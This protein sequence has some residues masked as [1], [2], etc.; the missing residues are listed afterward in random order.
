MKCSDPLMVIR[1]G[2]LAVMRRRPQGKGQSN[3]KGEENA[4]NKL[5][6][7]QSCLR[8]ILEPF[9]GFYKLMRKGKHF[10]FCFFLLLFF[11]NQGLPFDL[12]ILFG[13]FALFKDFV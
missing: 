3:R 9:L 13:N 1:Y 7:S 4:R 6:N 11:L 12:V 10:V 8:P 2:A 5:I